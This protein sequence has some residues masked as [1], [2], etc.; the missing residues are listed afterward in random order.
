M[1][2]RDRSKVGLDPAHKESPKGFES[3]SQP[4]DHPS[5]FTDQHSIPL[6]FNWLWTSN[7]CLLSSIAIDSGRA[8]CALDFGNRARNSFR[9]FLAVN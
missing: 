9:E 7:S 1:V 4:K 8:K 3:S 2:G 6:Y 5:A